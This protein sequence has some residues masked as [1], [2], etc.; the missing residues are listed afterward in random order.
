MRLV[1]N[2][3]VVVSFLGVTS[4]LGI[5]ASAV[6]ARAVGPAVMGMLAIGLL[7]VELASILDNW[8][9]PAH[10]RRSSAADAEEV[11][12]FFTTHLTMKLSFAAVAAVGIYVAAPW[13]GAL[14]EADPEIFRLFAFVPPFGAA[15]S[16]I[17]N[18]L[19][20]RGRMVARGIMDLV[21]A[22]GYLAF[23]LFFVTSGP[24]A[25][26]GRIV[27]A[28][29]TLLVGAVLFFPG[30]EPPDTDLAKHYLDFGTKTTP[31]AVTMK[32]IFWADT[33]LIAF[34]LGNAEAGIYQIAYSIA[35]FQ[36]VAASAISTAL[37]PAL[38]RGAL[39]DGEGQFRVAFNQ[40]FMMV[41]ALIGLSAT[42]LVVGAPWI[43]PFL[44]GEAFLSSIP[45]LQLLA[46]SFFIDALALPSALALTAE[47]RPETVLK[48]QVA[49][50]VTNVGA[51]LVLIP[52]MGVNGA[53]VATFVTFTLG[54]ILNVAAAREVLDLA[55]PTDPQAYQS[56]YSD[57]YKEVVGLFSRFG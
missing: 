24:D 34:L 46:L 13:I 8:S 51:N 32:T 52:R 54:T 33:A 5:L 57:A 21:T 56:F 6:V 23:A 48:I 37:F 25:V 20:A 42:A 17:H 49:M 43:I 12:R 45:V 39:E 40:G 30:I 15:S 44:Y 27:A 41:A 16:A 55:P 53:V 18:T 50:A 10:V 7:I 47:G 3:G 26:I 29:G 14:F 4:L 22:G 28:G 19:E 1:R 2:T 36:V 38:S 9:T 31:S 35:F 11:P